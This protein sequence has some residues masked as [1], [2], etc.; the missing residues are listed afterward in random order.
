LK[1]LEKDPARRYLSA[2]LLADDLQRFLDG[3][4]IL[5]RPITPPVR[6]WR[7]CRRNPLVAGTS[8]AAFAALLAAAVIAVAFAV[9]SERG[10][11]A[12]K[13]ALDPS[14]THRKQSLRRLA[15]SSLERGLALCEQGDIPQGMWWLVRALEAAEGFD[16]LTFVAEANLATWGD[17]LCT[18]E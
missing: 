14:E 7:W 2:S 5:A 13:T 1:C 4:P 8:I 17:Q 10:R 12:L 6:F 15:E 16:D 3:R 11:K 18:L 9:S